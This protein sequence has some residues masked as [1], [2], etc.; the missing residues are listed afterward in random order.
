MH[1][2]QHAILY[3]YIRCGERLALIDAQSDAKGRN[4]EGRLQQIEV[5]NSANDLSATTTMQPMWE[6]CENI[7]TETM[8]PTS[9]SQA[10]R[11]Y[12]SMAYS[13]IRL[14]IRLFYFSSSCIQ[15]R[16]RCAERAELRKARRGNAR[17]SRKQRAEKQN[18]GVSRPNAVSELVR[19]VERRKQAGGGRRLGSNCQSDE[20]RD[21]DGGLD[22]VSGLQNP[23]RAAVVQA[24]HV[25]TNTT[26][27]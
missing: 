18:D 20:E 3:T 10:D 9:F 27:H 24:A 23:K 17:K 5:F 26:I 6:S 4:R 11:A 21:Y 16:R 22:P 13:S 1:Q 15:I 7:Y 14:E 12:I 25:V 2:Q 19:F 8:P